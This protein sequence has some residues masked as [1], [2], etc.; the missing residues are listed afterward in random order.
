M[1]PI[2]MDIFKIHGVS[3][4]ILIH[5]SRLYHF[6]G[7]RI[8]ESTRVC[9]GNVIRDQLSAYS[10]VDVVKRVSIALHS[11]VVTQREGRGGEGRD[12]DVRPLV[13]I[14]VELSLIHV[15]SRDVSHLLDA[16]Y[17]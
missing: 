15:V 6:V 1:L 4:T 10:S 17:S 8:V 14:W 11:A 5:P 9:A 7:V 16:G 12:V 2:I 3:N 13:V